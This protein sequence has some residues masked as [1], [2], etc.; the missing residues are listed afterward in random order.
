MMLTFVELS[1]IFEEACDGKLK[2]EHKEIDTFHEY[3]ET[4]FNPCWSKYAEWATNE[5][6][7]Y[8]SKLFD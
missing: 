4:S 8:I 2:L 7:L 6:P 1:T 5:L 3:I